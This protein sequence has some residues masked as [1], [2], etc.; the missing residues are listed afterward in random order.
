[1]LDANRAFNA[2]R[3]ASG[4]SAPQLLSTTQRTSRRLLTKLLLGALE[5]PLQK[6]RRVVV[7]TG[8]I[9]ARPCRHCSVVPQEPAAVP[10]FPADLRT[11]VIDLPV[12]HLLSCHCLRIR[13]G[14]R[15]AVDISF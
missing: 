9:R 7:R 14:I 3:A 13:L 8:L 11:H 15:F 4:H 1:M 10:S 2:G 6:G 5:P 12:S